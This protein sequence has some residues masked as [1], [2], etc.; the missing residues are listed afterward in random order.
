MRKFVAIGAVSLLFLAFIGCGSIKDAIEDK[1]SDTANDAASDDN[2]VR[3]DITGSKMSGAFA[4]TVSTIDVEEGQVIL[5]MTE[6]STDAGSGSEQD[7]RA[8]TV[9]ILNLT[10]DALNQDITLVAAD[11]SAPTEETPVATGSATYLERI[12]GTEY[13]A[14]IGTGTINI[15]EFSD[16]TDAAAIKGTLNV[17]FEMTDTTTYTEPIVLP[18]LGFDISDAN[19]KSK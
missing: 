13:V 8:I 6:T 19:E 3:G 1:V 11:A 15:S 4:A 10:A 2:T 7:Q 12:G 16:A 18:E 17:S 9:T 14:P 5:T